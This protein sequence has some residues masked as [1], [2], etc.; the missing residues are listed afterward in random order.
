MGIGS[1]VKKLMKIDDLIKG[2]LKDE[3]EVMKD[4]SIELLRGLKSIKDVIA[5]TNFRNLTKE[6][7]GEI[8]G[9]A[10]REV[11]SFVSHL[12]ALEKLDER[13]EVIKRH[14]EFLKTN[15]EEFKDTL[16]V[17]GDSKKAVIDFENNVLYQLKVTVLRDFEEDIDFNKRVEKALE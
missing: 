10:R 4:I 14:A 16:D 12:S 3:I 8:L 15:L 2:R 1:N 9:D 13:F 17:Y 7:S 5:K 6:S 11:D